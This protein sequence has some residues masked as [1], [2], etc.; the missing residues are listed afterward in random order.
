MPAIKSLHRAEQES[1]VVQ[2]KKGRRFSGL[3]PL[4]PG[5][6]T[7][8]R[9]S[10]KGAELGEPGSGTHLSSLKLLVIFCHSAKSEDAS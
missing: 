6:N 8:L 1:R 10:H 4:L 3:G 9:G 2:D 5:A 7:P